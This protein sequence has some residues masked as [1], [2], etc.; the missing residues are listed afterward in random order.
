MTPSEQ[1]SEVARAA[2]PITIASMTVIGFT[3]ADW[4]LFL[5][6]IYTLLQIGL[7]IR[8]LWITRNDNHQPPRCAN[9]NDCPGRKEP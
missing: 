7:I 9:A 4:V 2:P 1:M 8:R 5:T 3:I 6:A